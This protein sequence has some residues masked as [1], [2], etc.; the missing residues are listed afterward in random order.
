MKKYLNAVVWIL[1]FHLL[2]CQKTKKKSVKEVNLNLHHNIAP[3]L[4]GLISKYDTLKFFEIL[5]RMHKIFTLS[6]RIVDN[7]LKNWEQKF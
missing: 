5:W 2:I 3:K 1:Y 7:Q 6:S 4:P